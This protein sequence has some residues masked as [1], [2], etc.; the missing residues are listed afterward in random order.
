[1]EE[2]NTTSYESI[3]VLDKFTKWVED[4]C[5]ENGVIDYKENDQY[6]IIIN[7]PHDDIRG[8]SNDECF[9]Y[10]L[11]LMNYASLLQ[12]KYDVVH[13]QHIWCVEALNFLY[14]KYWDRYDK[15][16]PA[17]IKKKSIILDN[18]FAQSVEKARIRLYAAMQILSES[19]KDVRKRVSILQD[20]GKHRSFK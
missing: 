4:F 18:S 2:F 7:M 19:A 1:M 16:L 12:K 20:L 14:A 6:E 3:E 9:A 10:A 13:S 11:T 17:E 8:L 15:Y 5:V